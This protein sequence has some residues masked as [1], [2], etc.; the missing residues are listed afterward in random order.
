MAD[1]QHLTVSVRPAPSAPPSPD[2]QRPTRN[3]FGLKG[4]KYV[5]VVLLVV[6]IAYLVVLSIGGM[7]DIKKL[8]GTVI[9]EASRVQFYKEGILGAWIPV[10]GILL[11]GAFSLVNLLEIGLSGFSF[12]GPLWFRIVTFAFCGGLLV[13]LLYQIIQYFVSA[14]FR[15]Q[16]KLKFSTTTSG[17]YYDSVVASMIPR[18]K[19]EKTWW[20]FLSA[21]AGI[22]EEIVWRGFL[23]FLLIAVFPSW[24]IAVVIVV[25]SIVFGAGHL[26]Q[27]PTGFVKTSLVG[28]LLGCLYV[29]TGSLLPGILLHFISDYSSA[30]LL[31]EDAEESAS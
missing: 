14:D 7:N 13:V 6:L 3:S 19:K 25:A 16:V 11:I 26:Y 9:T 27:G 4:V 30:F 12:W 17:N 15:E 29:A 21:S 31:S 28:V 23:Y 18:T 22:C 1:H 8:K 24:P 5:Y 20:F 10:A 2:P